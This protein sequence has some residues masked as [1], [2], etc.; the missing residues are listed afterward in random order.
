[1][2]EDEELRSY[3]QQIVDALRAIGED[4]T[5][6]AGQLSQIIENQQSAGNQLEEIAQ[7]TS[8][9]S[10]TLAKFFAAW[11]AANTPTP[12]GA[13][14]G[15]LSI[16][17][18]NNMGLTVDTAN[19]AVVLAFEDDHGDVTGPP[20]G[21]GSGLAVTFSSAETGVISVGAAVA[22]TDAA[23]NGNYSAPLTFGV[24]GSADLSAVVANVSGAPLTDADGTTPFKQPATI[25]VPVAAGQAVTGV[26]SA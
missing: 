18:G 1:M 11:Q 7:S 8:T 22:G 12:G 21:D 17:G 5:G 14:T 10:D 24:D 9:T 6:I 19:A 15:V 16:Q 20:P 4:L 13:T 3:N 26:E 2:L 23:G 25:T